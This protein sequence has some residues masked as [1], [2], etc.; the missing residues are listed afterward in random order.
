[1]IAGLASGAWSDRRPA[2]LV[3]RLVTA[4][5]LAGTV[6]VLAA[7]TPTPGPASPG[8]QASL[9]AIIEVVRQPDFP[10]SDFLP[11]Q[12]QLVSRLGYRLSQAIEEW[13]APRSVTVSRGDQPFQD[14]V[15]FYYPDNSY[16]YFWN[17]RIWQ[18]RLDRRYRGRAFGI[19][20]GM[21][22]DQ[23]RGV[24]GPATLDSATMLRYALPEQGWPVELLLFFKDGRL[25][26]LYLRRGDF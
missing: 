11:W 26:D 25:D 14:T 7:Q 3:R 13:G 5:W 22:A 1:M 8:P 17:D 4:G 20:M 15:V 10:G 12:D 24:L 18:I 19:A 2:R 9:P 21:A 23:V 16:A 6:T